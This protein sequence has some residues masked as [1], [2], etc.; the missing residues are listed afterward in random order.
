MTLGCLLA[1]LDQREIQACTREQNRRCACKPGY[2]CTLMRQSGCRLCIP[3]RRCS[4]GFGVVT[5]GMGPAGPAG[6][7]DPLGSLLHGHRLISAA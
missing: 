5:P 4:P 7:G 6:L 3:Q 1:P 2:Y